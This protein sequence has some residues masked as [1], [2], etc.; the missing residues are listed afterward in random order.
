[1]KT[2]RS[3]DWFKI[4]DKDLKLAKI[5]KDQLD[6][7]YGVGFHCQQAVEKYLKGYLILKSGNYPKIHDLPLLLELCYHFEIGFKKFLHNCETLSN[8][9]LEERYPLGE[10]KYSKQ[11]VAQF[12]K[13]AEELVNFVKKIV[14]KTI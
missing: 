5:L 1:M 12:I 3:Q 8:L 6:F 2:L 4:A 14:K 11:D 9:Y 7:A 10:E 13:L